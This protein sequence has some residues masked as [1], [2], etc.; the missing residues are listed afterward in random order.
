MPGTARTIGAS[1]GTVIRCTP[2]LY[3]S[4]SSRLP[5]A[6][7]APTFALVIIDPGTRSQAMCPSG[8]VGAR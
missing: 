7:T 3:C 4:V 2:S 5:V 8:T 6:C 1:A